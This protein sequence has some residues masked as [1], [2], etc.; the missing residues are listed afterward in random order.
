[1][2]RKEP[3]HR[4]LKGDLVVLE[5]FFKLF[6]RFIPIPNVLFCDLQLGTTFLVFSNLLQLMLLGDL[7]LVVHPRIIEVVVIRYGT[8]DNAVSRALLQEFFGIFLI[9]PRIE[10]SCL[11]SGSSNFSYRIV[12]PK[13]QEQVYGTSIVIVYLR[14]RA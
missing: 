12:W 4:D 6:N 2:P 14:G 7:A 5:S 11:Y 13:A 1:M 9:A 10:I 3:C 8:K